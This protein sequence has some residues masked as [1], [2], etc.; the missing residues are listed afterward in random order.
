M[1]TGKILHQFNLIY[2]FNF[3]LSNIFGASNNKLVTSK[4]I[5]KLFEKLCHLMATMR[6]LNKW[7]DHLAILEI[8]FY[9]GNR[10][11]GQTNLFE[12]QVL[13]DASSHFIKCQK[14]SKIF[15]KNKNTLSIFEANLLHWLLFLRL[16]F[17]HLL[18]TVVADLE[19]S[20]LVLVFVQEEQFRCER[21]L[22]AKFVVF[23][24][25]FFNFQLCKLASF[26]LHYNIFKDLIE[27]L[28]RR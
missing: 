3:V 22:N 17:L 21:I 23:I 8:I 9:L 7:Q 10:F 4:Q 2:Y 18:I 28:Y 12:Q 13:L 15:V 6:S 25:N 19:I 20:I 14:C 11:F 1:L 24:I 16:S 5:I 26:A 27:F